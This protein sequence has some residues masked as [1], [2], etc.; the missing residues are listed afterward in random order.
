MYNNLFKNLSGVKGI[1]NTGTMRIKI[2]KA[3]YV[4]I[5]QMNVKI[6]N[7]MQSVVATIPL[8][9][10]I[11]RVNYRRK[12]RNS[13]EMVGTTNNSHTISFINHTQV[14]FLKRTQVQIF[15]LMGLEDWPKFLKEII[16]E[17]KELRPKIMSQIEK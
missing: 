2:M 4:K 5:S 6:H 3:V 11:W 13:H 15:L 10:K 7:D 1:K 12:I 16:S 17:P 9:K 14:Q 8:I